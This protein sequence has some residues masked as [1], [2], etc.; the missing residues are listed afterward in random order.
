MNKFKPKIEFWD[1]DKIL[2]YWNNTKTHTDD[3]VAYISSLISE[4][5]N[6]VPIVVD[7]GGVIIKGHGRR[8]AQIKL[9]IKKVPVIVRTDLSEQKVKASRIS[10]NKSN[11]SAWDETALKVELESLDEFDLTLTGFDDFE[12]SDLELGEDDNNDFSDKNKE[13]DLDD[14]NDNMELK[15]KFNKEQFDFVT[16]RLRNINDSLEIALM[17]VLEY[18]S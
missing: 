5:G 18:E 16:E 11:E 3:Q 15:L 4:F 13:L 9:G 8:L 17:Q 12:F 14:F 10:D 1:I 2:P 6:D 7:S